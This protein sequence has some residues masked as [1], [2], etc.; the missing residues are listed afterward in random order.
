[1]RRIFKLCNRK[2]TPTAIKT[3]GA[4]GNRAGCPARG[5]MLENSSTG[6]PSWRRFAVWYASKAM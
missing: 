5:T 3:V 1:M 2:S 6:W 4:S